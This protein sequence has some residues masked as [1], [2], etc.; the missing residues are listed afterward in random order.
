MST[1]GLPFP[2]VCFPANDVW[3]IDL[4][5]GHVMLGYFPRGII[6]GINI[7]KQDK[8]E[9][10]FENYC[11]LACWADLVKAIRTLDYEG[12]RGSS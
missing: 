12:K 8:M 11:C 3:T 7:F 5:I 2:A 9:E 10:M 4:I 1:D 6:A